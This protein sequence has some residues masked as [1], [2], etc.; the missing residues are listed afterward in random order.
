MRRS[1]ISA[2]AS[3]TTPRSMPEPLRDCGVAH[4]PF[5]SLV[6]AQVLKFRARMR[7]QV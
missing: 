7:H 6:V 3:A 5:A 4:C 1:A 2:S